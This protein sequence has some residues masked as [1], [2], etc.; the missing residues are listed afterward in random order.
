MSKRKE[1]IL[2]DVAGFLTG[3]AGVARGVAEEVRTFVREEQE[4][5]VQKLDLPSPERIKALGEMAALAREENVRLEQ[6]LKILEKRLA[7]L[8]K[9]SKKSSKKS[10]KK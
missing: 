7:A 3:A 1:R 8:E 2:D 9:N 6:R 4:R 5:F 10:S